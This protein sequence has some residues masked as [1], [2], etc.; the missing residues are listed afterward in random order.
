MSSCSCLSRRQLLR[1]SLAGSTAF[2]ASALPLPPH[3]LASMNPDRLGNRP[4]LHSDEHLTLDQ[5][6]VTPKGTP[7]G[8]DVHVELYRDG[9]TFVRFHAHCSS[10]FGSFNFT[11]RAYASAPNA[12]T[13]AFLHSGHVSGV[14]SADHEEWGHNPL[15]SFFYDAFAAQPGYQVAKDYTWAGVVGAAEQLFADLLDVGA[16]VVGE[17]LGVVLAA[18]REATDWLDTTLGPGGTLAVISGFAIFALGA[19]QGANLGASLIAATVEGVAIGLLTEAL[20]D[21]R[22][23]NNAEVA[24][25]RQ[26]FGD[27]IDYSKVRLTNLSGFGKR[28][29]TVPGADGKTYI[30]IGPGYGDAS[31][32]T[33]PNYPY[34]GQLLIHELTHAWQIEHS[35]FLPGWM[36]HAV[37]NQANNTFVESAYKYGGAG[38]AWGDFNWE[39]QGSIVDDWFGGQGNS[40]GYWPMDQE[41]P[42]YNYVWTNL[43]NHNPAPSAPANLRATSGISVSRMPNLIDVFYP[44]PDGS[45]GTAW[46]NGQ[47]NTPFT[48]A[49]PGSA[50]PGTVACLGR[51]PFNLDI[52]WAGPDGSVFGVWWNNGWNARY[53]LA[54][55][56]SAMPGSVAA[57]NQNQNHTDVFWIAPDG[58]IGTT[59]W[60]INAGWGTPYTITPPG[61]AAGGLAA[62]ARLPGHLDLFWVTP[63]GEIAST[64]WDASAVGWAPIFTLSPRGSALPASGSVATAC[65]L[66][67]HI[68]V[69]YV[70]S[71]GSVMTTWWE[72]GPNNGAWNAPFSIAPSGSANGAVSAV[73]RTPSSVDVAWIGAD[74]SVGYAGW[75]ADS[76]NGAWRAPFTI[77]PAGSAAP[78]S[79]ISLLARLPVHLDVFWVAPD[80][81]IGTVWWD[82]LVNNSKWNPNFTVAPAGSALV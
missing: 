11:L 29:F 54:G 12:P 67:N 13:I 51:M 25:A 64:W 79:V 28:P 15:V 42:Y 31:T 65:R 40:N 30:N 49:G 24:L 39:Q 60:D 22:R 44:T 36:C 78:T 59:W 81:A 76:N 46:F 77:S 43:L 50:A 27:T 55:A 70:G 26:V 6:W 1:S 37:I 73:S 63:F 33:K 69:F 72:G 16:A 19:A 80:G 23:L 62:V 10:I 53:T 7:L 75:S 35:D 8:G 45:L 66:Q 71:D 17:T 20:V 47:W 57:T 41:N 34:P 48:V 82:G 61:S 3:A 14:D 2:A 21:H 68:D 56:G 32:Y 74:G 38:P 9:R 52:F 4:Q 58:S 18:T 5:V